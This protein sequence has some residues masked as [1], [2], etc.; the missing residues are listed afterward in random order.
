MPTLTFSNS[1]DTYIVNAAGTFDLTFLAGNDSLTTQHAGATTTASMGD[2]ADLV[3]HKAG[4]ANVT[5]GAGIDRFEVYASGLTADGGAD[6]DLFNIRGGSGLSLSGGIGNDRFNFAAASTSILLHGND[7]ADV[8]LGYGKAISGNI[9]GDAG[10][11]YFL[12]FRSGVTLR[13]GTGNDVFRADAISPATFVE[14]LN[15]G[16]DTVQV[17][18]GATYTLPANIENISVQTFSGSTS[19]FAT[20]TGNDLANRI[21]GHVNVELID[22]LAGN[23]VIS[24][25][26][27]NDIVN[28]GDGNDYLDGGDGG[29]SLYGG[30][31]NDRLVGRTGADAMSGGAGN[32][33]YYVDNELDVVTEFPGDGTDTVRVVDDV[34]VFAVTG[35]Y[36]LPDNVE[37]GIITNG[38]A[39][40][41]TEFAGNELDNL[42]IGGAGPDVIVAGAGDDDIRGGEGLDQLTG[43]DYADSPP[44]NDVLSGGNGDDYLAGNG[45]DDRL[46]GGAGDDRLVGGVGNDVLIGGENQ[47]EISTG[48]GA[49][50]VVYLNSL[51][52]VIDSEGSHFYENLDDFDVAFDKIDL[53]AVDAHIFSDID[54]PFH[55]TGTTP[56]GTVGDVWLAASDDPEWF[57]LYAENSNDGIPDMAIYIKLPGGAASFT[58]DNLIL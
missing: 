32:D 20:L 40:T 3:S 47:D 13:G 17:A 6:N 42:L 31:G 45:G 21:T 18:R 2:G 46:T 7:G 52:A 25:K 49:D 51:D 8:F 34:T 38:D 1:N 28:G 30:A 24:A 19:D 44:G 35:G 27:G 39:G 12:D 23:D 57:L 33:L 50:V 16:I 53:S 14:G 56:D 29:D 15:Q 9:Y 36:Q 10:N 58:A 4:T 26:G 54:Q 41:Q 5:G 43:D 37:N 48:D 11:D 22:G 55:F